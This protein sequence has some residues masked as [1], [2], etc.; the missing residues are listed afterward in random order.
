M[1]SFDEKSTKLTIMAA[2]TVYFIQGGAHLQ[3][4]KIVTCF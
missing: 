3:L 2:L 1:K 4:L